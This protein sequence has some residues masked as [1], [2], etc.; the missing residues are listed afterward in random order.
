MARGKD[1][2]SSVGDVQRPPAEVLYEGELAKLREGDKGP[3]PPGWHLSLRAVRTFVIGDPAI[4][5][6]KKFVGNAALV[7]RAMVA[8]AT[9]RGLLLVGE[10]GTAKSLLSELLA[11]AISGCST[12]TVQG[13]AATTEDHI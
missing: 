2:P 4:G 12:R 13:S 11:A 10:P 3:K 6:R 7:E 9:N 5:I 8:L 1:G